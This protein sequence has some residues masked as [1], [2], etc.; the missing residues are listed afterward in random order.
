MVEHACGVI[1][2]VEYA[3]EADLDRRAPK[4]KV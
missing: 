2:I 4:L 3:R 1:T